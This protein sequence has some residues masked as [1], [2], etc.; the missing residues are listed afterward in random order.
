MAAEAEQRRQEPSAGLAGTNHYQHLGY[1]HFQSGPIAKA[2]YPPKLN[3]AFL[4][5]ARVTDN[6]ISCPYL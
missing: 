6:C 5:I 2:S 4:L 3:V 1:L